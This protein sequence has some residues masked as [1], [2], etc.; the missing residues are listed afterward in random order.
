VVVI[1]GTT[2]RITPEVDFHIGSI[3]VVK[4]SAS[5]AMQ[6]PP[7]WGLGRVGSRRVIQETYSRSIW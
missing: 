4:S 3:T 6:E 2:E 5:C 7:K 1:D